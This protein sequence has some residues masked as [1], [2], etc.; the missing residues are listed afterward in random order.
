MIVKIRSITE[1]YTPLVCRR[2]GGSDWEYGG[3]N[4]TEQFYDGGELDGEPYYVH[5]DIYR[6]KGC[7][8]TIMIDP[9]EYPHWWRPTTVSDDSPATAGNA[10]EE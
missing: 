2:C 1:Q 4:E 3:Q 10:Q 8:Q 7:T 9:E 6:C 5:Q